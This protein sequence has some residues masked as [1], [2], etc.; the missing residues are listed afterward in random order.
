MA[1]ILKVDKYQDFNG[2]DIMTSDG[3]GN[4]T[5]NNVALKNT[6]AFKAYNGSNQTISTSSS[7]TIQANTEFYDTDGYYDTSTYRFTPLVSG[8]YFLFAIGKLGLSSGNYFES[9]IYKNNSTQVLRNV[10]H[11]S[12]GVDILN[13]V[14]GVVEA[15]GTTDYFTWLISHNYGSDRTLD[16]ENNTSFWGG[17]KIIE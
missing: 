15:N 12:A 4:I 10:V 16:S 8:K 5:I 13:I 6:P 2:N 7:T 3:A 14:S 1:G 11:V 9:K 17:Y